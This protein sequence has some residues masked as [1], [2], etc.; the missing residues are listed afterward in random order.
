MGY[1]LALFEDGEIDEELVCPICKGVL[2]AAMCAPNCEH[3]FCTDC[4]KEWLSQHQTCPLDRTAL[5]FA[6]M[7]SVPRILKNLLGKLRIKCENTTHGCDQIV[8]LDILADHSQNCEFN[9]KR[10]IRCEQC[11][12]TI[13]KN[14]LKDHNCI[15]DLRKQVLALTD[16]VTSL[17]QFKKDQSAKDQQHRRELELI[18]DLLRNQ[19]NP[20]IRTPH[21]GMSLRLQ[22]FE[23]EILRWSENLNSARVTRWGGVISTPDSV[24][25]RVIRRSLIES[26]CPT[27]IVQDLIENA[28]ER[29]WPRGLATLETRQL[30]RRYYDDY[31]TKRIPGK[32][33]VV[34]LMC[35]N[36]HMPNDM[37]SDPGIVMIFAHGVED[38]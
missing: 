9:P 36:G 38:V 32:Q 35:E 31:V 10:P 29:K 13:P 7:K 11:Q 3:A 27:H 1:D 18:K 37:I 26:G 16:K 33:A 24:L 22:Q 12:I 5:E 30:N 23:E 25:Q 8:R 20:L 21:S 19:N 6:Q 34:V 14:E 28:H 4:I 15:R 2:E 17:E